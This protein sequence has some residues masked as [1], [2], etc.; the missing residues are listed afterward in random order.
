M[1]KITDFLWKFWLGNRYYGVGYTDL[2]IE[3]IKE[4]ESRLYNLQ[5]EIF[6][7]ISQ[8]KDCQPDSVES[9]IR[10]VIKLLWERDAELLKEITGYELDT[11]PSVL[12]F[13]EILYNYDQRSD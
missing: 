4:D 6:D 1:S 9:D 13:L 7:V 5:R 8:R 3:L 10:T 11:E 12:Q 2:A